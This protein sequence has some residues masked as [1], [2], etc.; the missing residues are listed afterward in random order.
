MAATGCTATT[1]GLTAESAA[2]STAGSMVGSM[3]GSTTMIE[4]IAES[5]LG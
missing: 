5:M 4:L 2:W 1:A 3:A